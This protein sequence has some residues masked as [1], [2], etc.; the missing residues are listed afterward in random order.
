MIKHLWPVL[1][2]SGFAVGMCAQQSADTSFVPRQAVLNPKTASDLPKGYFHYASLK[3]QSLKNADT[4]AAVDAMRMMAIAA[5]KIGDLSESENQSVEALQLITNF[6]SQPDAISSR[7]LGLYNQL[8]RLY[9]D[10]DLFDQALDY[11]DKALSVATTVT[12]S[13][14]IINNHGNVYRAQEDY[15]AAIKDYSWVMEKARGINDTLALARTINNYGAVL[16]KQQRSEALPVLLEGLR[17]RQLK[18]SQEGLFGSYR[19]LVYYYQAQN[20]LQQAKVYANNCLS[21]AKALN[22]TAYLKEAYNLL[23]DL[24]EDDLVLGYK[25]ISD[26]LN[27]VNRTVQNLYAAMRFDVNQEKLINQRTLVELQKERSEKQFT[28]LI[29]ALVGLLLLVI[30]LFILYRIRHIKQ[31]EVFITENRISKKVHD[32]VANE[33][34]QLMVKMQLK[35]ENLEDLLD[36]LEFI[37]NRSRD[38]SKEFNTIDNNLPYNDVLLDLLSSYQSDNLR[39]INRNVSKYN[40][41]ALSQNKKNA[42]YRVLQ[43]LL[44][45]MKKHSQATLVVVSVSQQGKKTD[46]KYTDNGVGTVLKKQNGLQNAENRIF[47]LNGSITFETAPGNGFQVKIVI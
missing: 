1:I 18:N 36:D 43:E 8:G 9:E 30:I 2:V 40:W 35:H 33:V 15:Q 12:D 24:S 47:A 22:S 21:I 10:K 26:S 34:Y 6:K 17:L 7:I 5:F 11:Y 41:N 32:E 31:K 4:I 29:A 44:T 46:I 45:N 42:I 23:L 37:Y 14:T 16:I 13:I 27:V 38:I 25:K 28:L 19:H 39:I 3:D 20:N